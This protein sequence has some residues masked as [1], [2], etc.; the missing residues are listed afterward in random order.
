MAKRLLPLWPREIDPDYFPDEV[1][2]LFITTAY[3]LH[4]TWCD[5]YDKFMALRTV[6]WQFNNVI[7]TH[8]VPSLRELPC[9]VVNLLAINRLCVFK[10]LTN[11][12]LLARSAN[13]KLFS[14]LPRLTTLTIEPYYGHEEVD[15]AALAS[16]LTQCHSLTDLTLNRIQ[17][18]AED[19]LL[20]LTQL[21]A[22][23]LQNCRTRYSLTTLSALTDL[24]IRND[25]AFRDEIYL[26]DTFALCM[27]HLRWLKLHWDQPV[28]HLE[29]LTALEALDIGEPPQAALTDD[30]LIK[31]TRLK[32]LR[33]C[34]MTH[35]TDEGLRRAT[36]LT[37]LDLR[38]C[39]DFTTRAV[40]TLCNLEWLM[41][42]AKAA[43]RASQVQCR[44]KR[45]NNCCPTVRFTRIINKNRHA[46]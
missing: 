9:A 32:E 5:T 34:S 12:E 30:L 40:E 31:L 10:G 24:E 17:W 7:V 35:V 6:S 43:I 46:N 14:S 42:L 3:G 38:E 1:V 11:I 33:L 21:R 22:L 26:P 15:Y 36:Q 27:P 2:A 25:F 44:W 13:L 8:V 37:S 29:S 28:Y 16:S 20:P 4:F 39:P 18:M 19:A 45:W 41:I 23:R